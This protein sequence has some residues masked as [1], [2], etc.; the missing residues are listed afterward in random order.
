MR[1]GNVRPPHPIPRPPQGMFQP[2]MGMRSRELLPVTPNPPQLTVQGNE[3]VMESI[4]N[5]NLFFISV[6]LTFVSFQACPLVIN[7]ITMILFTQKAVSLAFP[8]FP[9]L[10]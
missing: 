4:V 8:E 3:N 5:I 6:C 10:L 1:L 7:A 9:L 2:V